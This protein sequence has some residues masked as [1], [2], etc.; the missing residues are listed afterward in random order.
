MAR[1]FAEPFTRFFDRFYLEPFGLEETRNFIIRPLSLSKAGVTIEEEVIE[2]IYKLTG[3][4][5]YFLSFIMKSLVDLAEKGNISCKIFNKI[6]PAISEYLSRE[7]F[8]EWI[9]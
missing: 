2:E 4:H 8:K 9:S 3:G 6:Y 7:K 5:P 1:E